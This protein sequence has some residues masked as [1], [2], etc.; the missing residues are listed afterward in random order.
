MAAITPT[1]TIS[2]SK[3]TVKVLQDLTEALTAA[4]AKSNEET[5]EGEPAEETTEAEPEET[6]EAEP[7]AADDDFGL[8]EEETPEE[9]TRDDVRNKL[10][11]YA[12]LTSQADGIRVLKK[13]GAE[14]L[15]KLDEDKFAEV[16]EFTEKLIKKAKKK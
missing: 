4:I 15:P 12:K 3:E 6:T 10:K 14:S 13:F 9:V 8:G 1:L 2:L 16:I 11:E 7:E 5:N